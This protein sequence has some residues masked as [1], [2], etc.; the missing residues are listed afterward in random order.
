MVRPPASGPIV[1]CT[2][3][4]RSQ[5]RHSSRGSF[6]TCVLLVVLCSAPSVPQSVFTIT[7]KA[8]TRAFSWLK[9]PIRAFTFKTLLRHYAKTGVDPT[10][11]RHEIG[12]ATQLSSGTGAYKTPCKP[13]RPSLMTFVSATQF[14][15]YLPWGQRLFSI[16]S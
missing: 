5:R 7:E 16:V 10:V 6:R 8:P 15:V 11:S 3:P 4:T 14:H 13:S 1:Q 9:A 12:S 2:H